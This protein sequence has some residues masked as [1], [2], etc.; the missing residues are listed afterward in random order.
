MVPDY[1]PKWLYS[2]Q[3][4]IRNIWDHGCIIWLNFENLEC[5][6]WFLTFILI[7]YLKLTSISSSFCTLSGLMCLL[8]PV[9]FGLFFYWAVLFIFYWTVSIWPVFCWAVLHFNLDWF[10]GVPYTLQA[11]TFWDKYNLSNF[12]QLCWTTL[13][14]ASSLWYLSM[15]RICKILF[16]SICIII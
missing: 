3:I 9:V 5:I 8:L 13:T 7:F 6:K 4:Y 15:N 2:L 12:V 1:F 14:Y 10:L 11:K 16:G